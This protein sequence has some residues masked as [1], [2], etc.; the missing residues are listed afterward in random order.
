MA[1]RQDS[2][3]V[4]YFYGARTWRDLFQLD[5]LRSFEQRLPHFR[6]VP[7]LSEPQLGDAWDGEVELITEV[8]K[9]IIS[10]GI[11]QEAYMCGP[12]TMIDAAIITLQKLGVEESHIF[13]DKFVTKADMGN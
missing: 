13:Y 3:S 5:E 1:D 7:A 6:F 4:T 11:H 2:R 8:V 9:R 10:N 12:T